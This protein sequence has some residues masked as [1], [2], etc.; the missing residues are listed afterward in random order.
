[1]SLD[2]NYLWVSFGGAHGDLADYSLSSDLRQAVLRVAP[3]HKQAMDPKNGSVY[4]RL[5]AIDLNTEEPL[6]AM[7]SIVKASFEQGRQVSS[8]DGV[9]MPE[10][11]A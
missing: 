1:M 9:E 5:D 2:P 6:R 7:F 10:Q 8:G 4:I 11:Q 3:S